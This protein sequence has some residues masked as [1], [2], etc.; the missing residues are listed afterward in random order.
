MLRDPKVFNEDH[1]PDYAW[2]LSFATSYFMVDGILGYIRKYQ[3][4]NITLHHVFSI[5]VFGYVLFSGKNGYMM[6]N[7]YF[8]A[9]ITNPLIALSQI[10]ES[11][12]INNK[13]IL[14]LKSAF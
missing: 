3:N 10:L 7:L 4:F 6:M 9:E 8:W 13:I 1:G 5:G 2:I 12:G 14:A 11:R